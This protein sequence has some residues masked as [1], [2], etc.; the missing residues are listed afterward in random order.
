LLGENVYRHFSRD[1]RTRIIHSFCEIDPSVN[2]LLAVLDP[3]A[4]WLQTLLHSYPQRAILASTLI[5]RIN[6]FLQVQANSKCFEFCFVLQCIKYKDLLD[7]LNGEEVANF[8]RQMLTVVLEEKRKKLKRQ[9]FKLVVEA[10]M[11]ILFDLI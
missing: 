4:A 2:K 7:K 6:G 9:C 10:S 3:T 8:I 1:V 11:V 5:A